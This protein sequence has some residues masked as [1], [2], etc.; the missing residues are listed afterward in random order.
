MSPAPY[1]PAVSHAKIEPPPKPRERGFLH[2]SAQSM[3]PLAPCTLL[4]ETK[5]CLDGLNLVFCLL[6]TLLKASCTLHLTLDLDIELDLG[7]CA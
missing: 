3:R 6:C 2:I 1:M 7:L 4:S 5:T